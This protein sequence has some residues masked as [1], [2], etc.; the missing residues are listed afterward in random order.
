MKRY[1]AYFFRVIKHKYYVFLSCKKLGVPIFIA[2]WHDMDKFLPKE[3]IPYARV[4]F[5]KNGKPNKIYSDKSSYDPNNIKPVSEF[6][7]AWL[8]HQRNKHHWEAWVSIGDCGNLKPLP[9]PE[10]YLREMVADWMGAGMAYD[11][12]SNP[13]GWYFKNKY[14]I[15]MEKNSR[16]LL[17]VLLDDI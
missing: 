8:L 5:D 17:E 9:I 2:I 7:F 6:S 15:V 16:I 14:S 11:G 12:K 4:F 13:N 10:I 1:I 3:F